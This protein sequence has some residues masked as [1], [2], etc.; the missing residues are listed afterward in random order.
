VAIDVVIAVELR[1]RL[2]NFLLSPHS[3]GLL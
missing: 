3:T 2:M 1:T